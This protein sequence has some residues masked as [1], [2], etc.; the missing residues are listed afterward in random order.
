MKLESISRGRTK[1][2]RKA[3]RTTGLEQAKKQAQSR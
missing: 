3:R 2:S 1:P